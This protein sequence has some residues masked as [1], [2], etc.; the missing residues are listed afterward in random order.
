MTLLSFPSVVN[1]SVKTLQSEQQQQQQQQNKTNKSNKQ[2]SLKVS[3][4]ALE[5][6]RN[7]CFTEEETAACKKQ[8]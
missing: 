1:P 5:I 3:L 6:L 2:S 7:T 8:P 4:H